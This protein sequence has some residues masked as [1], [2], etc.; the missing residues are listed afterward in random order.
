VLS[1]GGSIDDVEEYVR[2]AASVR[3]CCHTKL[4]KIPKAPLEALIVAGRLSE[5]ARLATL[6]DDASANASKEELSRFIERRAV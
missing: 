5:I 2:R 3:P 6:L 1:G 4:I